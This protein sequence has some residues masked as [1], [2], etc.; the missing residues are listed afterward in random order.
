M[1]SSQTVATGNVFLI[2]APA[3]PDTTLA[4]ADFGIIA[5]R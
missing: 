5:S 3:T 2:S 4:D 1:S